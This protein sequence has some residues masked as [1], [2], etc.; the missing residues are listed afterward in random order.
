VNFFQNVISKSQYQAQF[1]RLHDP[2]IWGNHFPKLILKF[3]I[4]S[5]YYLRAEK[6]NDTSKKKKNKN[7]RKKVNKPLPS[8]KKE[9]NGNKLLLPKCCCHPPS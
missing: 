3:A 2:H 7:K 9:I 1:S 6:V 5:K 8:D 4:E